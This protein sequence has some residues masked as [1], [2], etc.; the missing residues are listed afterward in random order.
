L[1]QR[2]QEGL[3]LAELGSADTYAQTVADLILVVENSLMTSKRSCVPLSRP[4][5]IFCTSEALTTA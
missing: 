4:I 5:G 1:R 3:A 2:Q